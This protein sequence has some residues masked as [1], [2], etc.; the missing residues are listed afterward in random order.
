LRNLILAFLF[1]TQISKEIEPEKR[2][3]RKE[4]KEE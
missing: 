3:R 2:R 1:C 4:E